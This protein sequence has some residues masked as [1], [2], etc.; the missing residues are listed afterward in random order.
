MCITA[1]SASDRNAGSRF[2]LA[3][4]AASMAAAAGRL[5]E[6]IMS[7]PALRKLTARA[8]GDRLATAAAAPM[9]SEMI[10]PPKCIRVRSSVR[11]VREENTARC[12]GSI[13]G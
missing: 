8:A 5:S 2:I 6:R 10:T 12:R 13:L 1:A 7:P 3:T 4:T 11:I 9:S